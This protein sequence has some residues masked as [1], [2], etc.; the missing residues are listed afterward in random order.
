MPQDVV[1]GAFFSGKHSCQV[2]ILYKVAPGLYNCHDAL[3]LLPL[4]QVINE[5]AETPEYA[6]DLRRRGVDVLYDLAQQTLDI[7]DL[8]VRH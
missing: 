4:Q 6:V 5:A 2:G 7:L 1:T 8:V 3:L